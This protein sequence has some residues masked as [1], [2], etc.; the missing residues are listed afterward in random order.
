MALLLALW[1]LG[2]MKLRLVASYR[3]WQR[4]RR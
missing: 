2:E 1:W 3:R 4:R